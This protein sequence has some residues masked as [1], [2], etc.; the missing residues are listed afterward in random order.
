[1]LYVISPQ[2]KEQEK[3]SSD[4]ASGPYDHEPYGSNNLGEEQN[5]DISFSVSEGQE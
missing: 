4:A 3:S 1:M 5:S 2:K